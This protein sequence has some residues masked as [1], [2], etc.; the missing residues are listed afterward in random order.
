MNIRIVD[1]VFDP[2]A[3][4]DSL[5]SVRFAE[6]DMDYRYQIWIYLDGPDL[7]FIKEVW[8]RLP[9]SF[10]P[11]LY[12]VKRTIDN[13]NC[14]IELWTGVTFTFDA[15]VADT[16]GNLVRLPHEVGF[17]RELKANPNIKYVSTRLPVI[18]EP[19]SVNN[20]NVLLY[21]R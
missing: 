5:P 19:I 2:Y 13:P 7:L 10:T 16:R 21:S 15:L 20:Q 3:E 9:E 14:R 8:Y 1:S 17:D 6:S 11:N 12:H 18:A 4:G